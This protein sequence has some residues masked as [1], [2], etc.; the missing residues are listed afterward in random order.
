MSSV[1]DI[2]KLAIANEVKAKVYYE[3]AAE[4]AGG[5]ESQMVFLELVEME[6]THAQRLIDAFGDQ[7]QQVGLDPEDFL[8]QLTAN[9]EHSLGADETRLL[10]DA[11]MR[12]VLDFA[13]GMERT[14]RDMYL[15]LAGR[16]EGSALR[17]LC[18]DLADEEQQHH[19]LLSEA[20]SG[21]DTPIDERPAL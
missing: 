18:R 21:V 20:R 4:L 6:A 7:L 8:A 17:R 13:I 1:V 19:D 14:A 15:D 12:Q 5:G 9:T 3:K 11:D 10:Q 16:V 2:V